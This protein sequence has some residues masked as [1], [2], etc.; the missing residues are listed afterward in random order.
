M[1]DCSN[2]SLEGLWRVRNNIHLE[3]EEEFPVYRLT[4][5]EINITDGRQKL[6]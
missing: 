2:V 3:T 5:L 1:M 6:R 4:A